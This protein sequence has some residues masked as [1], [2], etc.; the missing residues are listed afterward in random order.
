MLIGDSI[1]NAYHHA[2]RDRL[3]EKANVSYLG[4]L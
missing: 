3:S 4:K 2:V 1:C